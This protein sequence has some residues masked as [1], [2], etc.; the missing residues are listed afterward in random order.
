MMYNFMLKREPFGIACYKAGQSF[1]NFQAIYTHLAKIQSKQHLRIC[2]VPTNLN[3]DCYLEDQWPPD[4]RHPSCKIPQ[5]INGTL[6]D[7][8]YFSKPS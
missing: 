2:C 8:F 3:S 6:H 5:T 7:M 4:L 1:I